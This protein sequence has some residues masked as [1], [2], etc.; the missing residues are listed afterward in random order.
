MT[1]PPSDPLIYRLAGRDDWARAQA[2]GVYR[3]AEVDVRDGYIHFSTAAQL[4]ETA[5]RHYRGRADAVLLAVPVAALGPALRWEVSRGG[6][7]FPHLYAALRTS[8]VLWAKDAP[9][10]TDGVPQTQDLL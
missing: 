7:L 6:D 5:R 1:R 10:D 4:G 2:E 3:G 9:P 8:D